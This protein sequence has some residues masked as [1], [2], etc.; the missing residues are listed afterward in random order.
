MITKKSKALV[1]WGRGNC[2][3]TTTLKLLIDKLISSGA[4]TLL[5]QPL[6]TNGIDCCA[7]LEQNVKKI[8]V[9]TAGDDEES[10]NQ[11][12][13]IINNYDC[14]VYVCASRSKGSTVDLLNKLFS[15][16]IIVW[17]EKWS[18]SGDSL[19]KNQLE[20]LQISANDSQSD[21]LLQTVKVL[22]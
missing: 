11:L 18:V 14:D 15:G 17:V 20:Q 5:K 16:N 4:N 10:I 19:A 8:A 6:H 2:G 13:D 7:V 21:G 1:L 9:I 12:L 3:K 22:I